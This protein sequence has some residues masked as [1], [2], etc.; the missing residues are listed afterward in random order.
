MVT[1]PSFSLLLLKYVKVTT[2]ASYDRHKDI[3]PHLENQRERVFTRVEVNM[4][5]FD[6][7][8]D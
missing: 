8:P 6:T 4:N 3:L 2:K 7:V 1:V 5:S